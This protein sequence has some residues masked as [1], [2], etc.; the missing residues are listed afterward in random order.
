MSVDEQGLDLR[1]KSRFLGLKLI[2]STPP[3]IVV[4]IFSNKEE[5]DS[6]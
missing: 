6:L 4:L 5:R 2:E 3:G 1:S